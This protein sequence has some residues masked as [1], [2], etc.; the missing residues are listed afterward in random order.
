MPFAA[1]ENVQESKENMFV[2]GVLAELRRSAASF[3]SRERLLF[4]LCNNVFW[5]VVGPERSTG[6]YGK[7]KNKKCSTLFMT[8]ILD[9]RV[10]VVVF[11]FFLRKEFIK[12]QVQFAAALLVSVGL[13]ARF[14]SPV[15]LFFLSRITNIQI[16]LNY[17]RK[18]CPLFLL[19]VEKVEQTSFTSGMSY[20]E[21]MSFLQLK[22]FFY[23]IFFYKDT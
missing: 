14:Y 13:L 1:L 10:V 20:K 3:C 22:I 12:V 9:Q 8:E 5:G 18:M 21:F 6:S 2:I 4:M 23:F 17:T 16:Y 19:R 7:I 15:G 11:C